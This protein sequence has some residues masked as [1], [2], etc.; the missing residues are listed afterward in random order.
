MNTLKDKDSL[1]QRILS[2]TQA[3]QGPVTV[4]TGTMPH[5]DHTHYTFEIV[6]I[7]P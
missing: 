4:A 7:N 2:Y 6:T 5:T 1:L 3:K